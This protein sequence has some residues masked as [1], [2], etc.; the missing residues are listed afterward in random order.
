[1][2]VGWKCVATVIVV[3][4]CVHIFHVESSQ[5]L[6]E[7]IK[8]IVNEPSSLFQRNLLF[9]A[10][11]KPNTNTA[12]FYFNDLVNYIA[13][14]VTSVSYKILFQNQKTFRKTKSLKVLLF[15][16]RDALS[17]FY[18]KINNTGNYNLSHNLMHISTITTFDV[19]VIT[20]VFAHLY[21][22]SILNVGLLVNLFD[23]DIIMVTYFPFTPGECHSIKPVIVNRYDPKQRQWLH[24]D[25]FPPKV[26]NFY[27]CPLT[28]AAWNEFPYINLEYNSN[29]NDVTKYKGFEGKLLQFLAES[30]NFTT[31]VYILNAT[32]VDETFKEPDFIFKEIFSKHADISLAGYY[33]KWALD[34]NTTYSQTDHY[35]LSHTYM[36][37]NIFSIYSTY[38]K[39]AL[40]FQLKLWYLIGSVFVLS[41]LLILTCGC[42]TGPRV[43]A[44]NYIIGEDNSTPQYHLLTLALGATMPTRQVPRYN[45]ARFLLVCWMLTTLVLRSAYQSGMYQMLRDNIQRNPPQTIADVLKQNYVILLKGT[46]M[47]LAQTLPDM[48][49]VRTL[50]G[51]FLQTF[52][53]LLQSNELTAIVTQYEYFGYFR[54][55]NAA[56]WHRLHLVNERIYTKP[57]AMNVRTHS[58]LVEEFN[59]Q[60]QTA[61]TF[62]FDT[63]WARESF[64]NQ[65]MKNNA[66]YDPKMLAT[67]NMSM[68][69]L[70]AVFM[71]LIWLHVMAMV[72]FIIELIWH[73]WGAAVLRNYHKTLAK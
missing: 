47:A 25:Y 33:Y 22:L 54:Q 37:A 59:R 28:C 9:Y 19:D 57:L 60:I 5:H 69:E 17:Y 66:D 29:G 13:P 46:H 70:G 67:K 49:N 4:S 50:N 48:R 10:N 65:A 42:C 23:E 6:F 18:A 30:L 71:I 11:Y 1:M 32:E 26:Q 61:K 72:I 58:Y 68:K 16:D 41:S 2:S 31:K 15:E 62:G 52:P 34:P 40:P 7:S 73:K 38:E 43:R 24:K 8:I 55:I 56:S 39:M 20:K 21:R 36:V 53:E 45:F 3:I 64:G 12:R 27:G 44:R 63:L 14:T 51:S 35:Y